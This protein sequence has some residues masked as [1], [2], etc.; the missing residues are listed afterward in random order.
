[1]TDLKKLKV[2][3]VGGG[4]GRS[5]IEGYLKLPDLFELVG[6]C[7]IDQTKAQEVV[8]AYNLPRY[9][10]DFNEVCQLKDV[11]VID[12]CTPPHLH[13][14]QI[15]QVLTA[16]KQVICEKPLVGSLREVDEIILAEAAANG[17]RVMPIFQY[18]FGHGLQKL[19]LLIDKGLVGKAYLSTIETAWR[20]R[21]D[22]YSVPWRG[23]WKTEM[24][25]AL[26][27][28]AIHSHDALTYIMGP[29]KSVFARTTTRVNPVEVED[30]AAISLEM[31]DGSLATLSVTLG[32]SKEIS[33]HHFCFAGLSA[34]SNNR[35]YN[36]SGDPWDFVGDTP[37][38]QAQ[39]EQTLADFKP[40]PEGFAGQFYRYY[41]A[42]QNGTELP[43]TLA[44]ARRALELIT[45]FYFSAETGLPVELPLGQENSKYNSWLP[46]L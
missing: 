11:D 33:R 34:E 24:G 6:I 14:A 3:V 44:D 40:L 43:V 18:R 28:H 29:A 16:G 30:C 1:M 27:T 12:L 36:N 4:I 39:I 2:V 13:F 17:K 25:G 37:E 42:L 46:Q 45:A 21:E 7:D 22:Y 32:S 38:L 31:A 23:K 19:K 35:P 41:Y 8:A 9:F 20:R 10:L 15:K 26:L 5:H